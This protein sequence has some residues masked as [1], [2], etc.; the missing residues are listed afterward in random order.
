MTGRIGVLGA[1]GMGS[2]YAAHLARAGADVVL[3]G[4][5]SAH[6]QALAA[7]P[8]QVDPPGGAPWK[9]DV[10]VA[11]HAADVAPGSL[12]V[13]LLLTKAYDL[14][15]AAASA[16]H[17]L[18]PDGVAVPLQNGLGT[19]ALVADVFGE[20][21]TL[22]GTT[23]VGAALADPGRITVSVSTAAGGSRTD[24]G[25]MGRGRAPVERGADVAAALSAA[26][27]SA[28]AVPQVDTLIWNKL[29]LA[30]M[31]PLSSVPRVTVATVWNSVE[32]R[33]LAERMA[34]EVVAV[35]HAEGV[36]LDRDAAL[37]HARA[38]WAGTGEHYTSMCT[39]VRN[40]RRTEL[41]GMG[42]AVARLADAHGVAVPVHTTVLGLLALAGVR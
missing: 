20:G 37:D 17:V 3:V 32:G 41:S 7:G 26:G 6:V 34:A 5:G 19:D 4:R 16:A 36:E 14:G 35:A 39:D 40:G 28:E 21:R 22:V 11:A 8:L 15:E 18:A 23:T 13:L 1:G 25:P 9:V 10:P 2:A 38:V 12:D 42:A 24:L 31:S 33:D 29:A 27:L 30:S